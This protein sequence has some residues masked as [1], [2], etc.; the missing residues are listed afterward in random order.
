MVE[1]EDDIEE[2]SVSFFYDE[3]LGDQLDIQLIEERRDSPEV[4]VDIDEL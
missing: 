2:S 1:L 4:E 3:N